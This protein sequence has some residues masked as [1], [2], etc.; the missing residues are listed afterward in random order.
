MRNK[1]KRRPAKHR[2]DIPCTY[3]EAWNLGYL[4]EPAY[5]CLNKRYSLNWVCFMHCAGVVQDMEDIYEYDEDMHPDKISALR[6]ISASGAMENIDVTNAMIWENYRNY[7]VSQT[8]SISEPVMV[9]IG[10][11]MNTL[12]HGLFM[13]ME[14]GR[15]QYVQILLGHC[16]KMKNKTGQ[17]FSSCFMQVSQKIL[18][19][20]RVKAEHFANN[21]NSDPCSCCPPFE[22][23]S[24][25]ESTLRLSDA[26]ICA[27]IITNPNIERGTIL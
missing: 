21:W 1:R 17:D 22:Y 13:D 23:V 18:K 15:Q 10:Q 4:T 5:I 24:N 19:Q 16:M 8:K 11:F 20:M 14:T 27:A 25:P 9:D 12:G 26:D 3:M 7:R 2:I 6:I